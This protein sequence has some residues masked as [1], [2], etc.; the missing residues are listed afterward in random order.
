MYTYHVLC[1]YLYSYLHAYT[2]KIALPSKNVVSC[3]TSC[4]YR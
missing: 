2:L 1:V 3:F 4:S